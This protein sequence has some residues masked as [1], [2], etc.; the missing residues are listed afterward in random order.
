M[1]ISW[2]WVSALASCLLLDTSGIAWAH[3]VVGPEEL[4]AGGYEK[5]TVTAPSEKEIPTTEVRVDVPEGF[6]VSGVKP[7][8]GWEYEF[9]EE[10]GVVTAVTW[11]GGQIGPREF[12]E[13]EM[14]AQTPDAPGDF[15]FGATQTYEDGST[16]EWTGPPDSENPASVVRVVS[17]SAGAHRHGGEEEAATA[18]PDEQTGDDLPETGGTSFPSVASTGLFAAGLALGLVAASLLRRRGSG[19]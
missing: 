19:A 8:P 12:Q 11:S 6:T 14:Q 16:A 15:S 5:L 3:V 17:S 2:L 10:A 18:A 4:A 9:E 13:F 1:K 7:V